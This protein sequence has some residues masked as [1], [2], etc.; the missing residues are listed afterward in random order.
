MEKIKTIEK[1]FM[2]CVLIALISCLFDIS[3]TYTF[4][5]KDV[6]NFFAFEEQRSLVGELKEGIP[7][8]LTI[9]AWIMLLSPI[10][11][12]YVVT[13]IQVFSKKIYKFNLIIGIPLLLI[14]SAV[15]IYGGLSWLI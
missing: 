2:I 6:N 10:L 9:S 13:S 3:V 4:Y 7:F 12:F 1:I 8:F 14:G 11:L 15:H 5:K